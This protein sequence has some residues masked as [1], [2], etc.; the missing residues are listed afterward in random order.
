MHHD[1]Y[2]IPTEYGLIYEKALLLIF[3]EFSES[4]KLETQ[5]DKTW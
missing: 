1:P 5:F 4:A 2:T 3:F